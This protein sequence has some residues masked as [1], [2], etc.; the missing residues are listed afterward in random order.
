MTSQSCKNTYKTLEEVF[1]DIDK[2]GLQV[3][4]TK[5][6]QYI[7]K[8]IFGNVWTDFDDNG[9]YDLVQD[10]PEHEVTIWKTDKSYHVLTKNF[11][12]YNFKK[13]DK[14]NRVYYPQNDN[15]LDNNTYMSIFFYEKI[16]TRCK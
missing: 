15:A 5:N 7:A 12:Q 14:L 3:K 10:G 9:D 8:V 4:L 13:F 11:Y 6:V 2:K 16:N 1:E